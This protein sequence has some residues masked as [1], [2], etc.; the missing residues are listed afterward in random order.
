MLRVVAVVEGLVGGTVATRCCG[1]PGAPAIL[2]LEAACRRGRGAPGAGR[3]AAAGAGAECRR[4]GGERL[5]ARRPAGRRGPAPVRAAGGGGEPGPGG[6]GRGQGR[7]R[8]RRGPGALGR[9]AARR[10][11]RPCGARLPPGVP[12]T[13]RP[14]RARLDA[15]RLLGRADEALWELAALLAPPTRLCRRPGPLPAGT[16]GPPSPAAVGAGA[17]GG[18][19]ARGGTDP[20]GQHGPTWRT[21]DQWL[22]PEGQ[23]RL[24]VISRTYRAGQ[25]QTCRT[26][27]SLWMFSILLTGEADQLRLVRHARSGLPGVRLRSGAGRRAGDAGQDPRQ[28]ALSGRARRWPTP[29][30]AWRFSPGSATTGEPPNRSP[31]GARRTSGR[32]VSPP[33]PRTTWPRSSTRVRS[34]PAPRWRCCARGTPG[35]SANSTGSRRP[36]PSCA[37]SSTA[38]GPRAT[39]RCRP[40]GCTWASCSDARAAWSRCASNWCCWRKEFSSRTVGVFFDGFVLGML[41]WLDN[42]DG[43]DASAPTALTALGRSQDRLSALMAPFHGVH[44]ADDHGP[45]ARRTRRRRSPGGR[46]PAAVRPPG[47]APAPRAVTPTALERQALAEAEEAVRA[48]HRRRG[49]HGGVQKRAA[50]ASRSRRPPPWWVRTGARP[51]V[52]AARPV[53]LATPS[54][55]GRS[56]LLA[57]L[58]DGQRRHH[59][60]DPGGL[61][62]A[63]HQT[64]SP[65]GLPCM[66]ARAA[67]AR[68]ESGL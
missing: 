38:A 9:G 10:P 5:P 27:G 22:A 48:P 14:G 58:G 34:A 21:M 12:Q 44:A 61:R 28:P 36:R 2:R 52:P 23:E 56:G 7:H 47:G 6:G 55:A 45:G 13:R 66:R 24:Q 1:R 4:V 46:G 3:A 31:P 68:L 11:P 18:G 30:R 33:P 49:V 59:H 60:R 35:S 29:T 39:R 37:R 17:G 25:P 20:A 62:R 64:E 8:P 19:A 57:E 63:S 50:A 41:A 51:P 26:P 16:G 43:D 40:P 67:S 42:L 54:V 15:L 65:T 53:S 32:A